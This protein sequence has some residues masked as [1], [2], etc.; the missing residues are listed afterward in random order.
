[1]GWSMVIEYIA[2]ICT[3]LKALLY[4]NQRPLSTLCILLQD[5][6]L[7][8]TWRLWRGWSCGMVNGHRV[9]CVHLYRTEGSSVPGDTGGA[10]H[11]EYS[12]FIEYIVYTCTG[13]KAL[14]YL[15]TLEGLDMW[16]GQWSL[17]TLCTLVPDSRLFCTWR[18]WRGCP[19]RILKVH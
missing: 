18:L 4:L 12:K 9:H 6:R 17:S 7:F 16:D 8:C 14:L 2:Y 3:G 1:V 13:L 19:L 15:E 11:L 5:S 10:G